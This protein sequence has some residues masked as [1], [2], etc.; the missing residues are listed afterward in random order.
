MHSNSSTVGHLL[1]W[2]PPQLLN[3]INWAPV[4]VNHIDQSDGDGSHYLSV[5][6]TSPSVNAALIKKSWRQIVFAAAAAAASEHNVSSVAGVETVRC[7]R[8]RAVFKSA[9][10]GP[11]PP[12]EAVGD[13]Q[14]CQ[15]RNVL[16]IWPRALPFM[17]HCTLPICLLER[18]G[19]FANRGG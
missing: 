1:V 4:F 10:V 12:T 5:P 17:C 16:R 9:G 11:A 8:G 6:L 3:G 2:G 15:L 13:T 18:V 19:V 7:R 14:L